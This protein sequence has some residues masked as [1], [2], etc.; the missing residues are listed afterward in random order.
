MN[1]RDLIFLISLMLLG[2]MYALNKSFDTDI[3]IIQIYHHLTLNFETLINIDKSLTRRFIQYTFIIPLL[4]VVLINFIILKKKSLLLKKIYFNKIFIIIFFSFSIL[5]TGNHI[6]ITHSMKIYLDANKVDYDSFNSEIIVGHNKPYKNLIVI[7]VEALEKG[8]SN[9]KVFSKDLLKEINNID[10]LTNITFDNYFSLGSDYTFLGLTSTMCGFFPG[11]IGLSKVNT[12]NADGNLGLYGDVFKKAECIGD[13]LKDHNY[14]NIYLG[15]ADKTFTAK[16]SFLKSHGFDEVYGKNDFKKIYEDKFFSNWGLN[17]DKLFSFAKDKLLEIK[18][19]KSNFFLNILT[20]DT[21]YPAGHSN[22]FCKKINLDKDY[23]H[24]I[25]CTAHLVRE[26]VDFLYKNDFFD[27]TN[28]LITS[29]QLAW[30]LKE[31]KIYK[32]KRLMFNN[33]LTKENKNKYVKN[34][35]YIDK[36]SIYPTLLSFIN[37]KVK[38]GH[39]GFGYSGFGKI[40]NFDKDKVYNEGNNKLIET[41]ESFQFSKKY[42]DLW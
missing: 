7:Y 23:Y 20:L 30:G 39:A 22:E 42:Y 4:I 35:N 15:G 29:D 31:N 2:T 16:N 11:P 8:Y 3:S 21:H 12:D 18:K 40:E 38:D 27:T 26:F 10:Y 37:F 24:R 14:Y 28:V 36:F 13:I 6:D 19:T 5:I 9:K 33:F 34:R 1:F 25:E 17:D 32:T 41:Y